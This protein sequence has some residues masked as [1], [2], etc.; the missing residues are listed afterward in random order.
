M[1][2]ERFRALAATFRVVR[3]GVG[4]LRMRP[5][6]HRFRANIMRYGSD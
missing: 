6:L 5:D 2:A 3:Y 4:V 1:T